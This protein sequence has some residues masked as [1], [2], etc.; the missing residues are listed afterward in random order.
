[1]IITRKTIWALLFTLGFSFLCAPQLIAQE[2]SPSFWENFFG[3]TPFPDDPTKN[4]LPF[5]IDKDSVINKPVVEGEGSVKPEPIDSEILN[6]D[7][8]EA[9]SKDPFV[10]GEDSVKPKRVTPE[11]LNKDTIEAPSKKSVIEGESLVESPATVP[12]V[13]EKGM[14]TVPPRDKKKFIDAGDFRDPFKLLREERESTGKVLKPGVTVDGIQFNSYNDSDLFIEK[15]YRDTRFRIKDV[16]GKVDHLEGG[17]CLYC[18]QGIE[19]ISENHKFRCTKCHEGNRRRRTLPAAHKNLISNP[20]DLDHAPKYCGKCHMDQIEQVEQSNMAT[21]K[22]IID[23]TRYAWGAQE[24]GENLYSLRPKEE[25]GEHFLP[26]PSEGEPVDAFLRTKCMRCHLQSEA[27]H[28][29]GDYRAGGCAACHMIYSNDGHTLTQDRAIQSKVRKTRAERKGRFKRK[30]AAKS[31]KNSR[32]YPVMHKFTTA[33]PSVQCEHCHNTNG[34][35][36]EFEGLFSPAARPNASFQKIGMDKPVLY[37]TE[38]EFLLPDIHR[39]RGMHCIDCHVATDLKGA[40]SGTDLHSGVEIRC[41]D[42]HGST[43]QEPK[44]TLL[45]ESDPKTKQLLASNALNPNL[46]RKIKVGDTILLNSGGVP[47]THVKKEEGKWVLYSRVTGKKHVMPL[48]VKEKSVVAHKVDRHMEVVECHA[49]HARWSTG[50]WG[51]HVIREGSL[52]SSKWKNWNFSDPTLQGMLWNTDQMSTGM[53]DWLSAKWMGDKLLGDTVPGIF[54]N[55]IAE[56]DWNTMILGKNQR[57]KYSIMKPRYQYF[58]TDH[59]ED[60]ENPVKSTQVPITKSEKPGLILLPHTPHTI[61][62]TVRSCESCHDS[63]IALGL[64]DPKRNVIVDAESFFSTLKNQGVVPSDF[65][66]KQVVT[67][68]GVPIQ[69]VYP[70]NRTRFLNAEE[71]AAIKNKSDTYKAFRYLDLKAQKFPRLLA[72]EEFPF[73]QKHKRNE[74]SAKQ[75]KQEEEILFKTNKNGFTTSEHE[76]DQPTREKAHDSVLGPAESQGNFF[77]QDRGYNGEPVESETIKEFSPDLFEV[78]AFDEGLN[79]EKDISTGESEFNSERFQ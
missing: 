23:V 16:F 59:S 54:L 61:R 76:I 8:V 62:K 74:E 15:V 26:N 53:I 71:I 39:E 44:A 6:K 70:N 25:D 52:D 18:H 30:F 20:S 41:E 1:M 35:G 11:V 38:H 37:G 42:C 32:A 33:I 10:E 27:P 7:V 29:P 64:G 19:R 55:L 65:Q 51:M 3:L 28:R 31:L 63:E 17:G 40:P 22:S 69:S 72:R 67:E 79:S 47:L 36:N 13:L 24:E 77:K 12:M 60:K 66:A 50:E 75:P 2:E 57:G 48:L 5:E 14:V 73:D 56:K 46:K 68:T 49:C 45:I 78:P 34:I 4:D 43:S 9:P 21:G 58:L